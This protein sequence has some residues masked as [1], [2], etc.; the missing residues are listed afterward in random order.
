MKYTILGAGIAGIGAG[1]RLGSEAII[2]EA[3][4]RY[5]G[6]LDN[7]VV[8]G[9]RFDQAIHLSFA[10][11]KIVRDVFDKTKYITHKPN[12][13][14]YV[15]G[16]WAKH[17][18]QN[19][20]FNLP[21]DK[22]ILAVESLL[23][24]KKDE[25]NNYEDWLNSQFGE[26]FTQNYPAR[27]TRKY[28][29]C[30]PS[31]LSINWVANR[32]YRPSVKEIIEGALIDTKHSTYY[33]KELRY[34]KTGGYRNFFEHIAENLNIKLNHKVTSI[35]L[36]EKAIEFNSRKKI[37]YKNLISSLPLPE[38][39]N[40]IQEVPD[41]VKEAA[42]KLEATSIILGSVGFNKKI[43]VPGLWFYIY[44]EDIPFARV[45]APCIK[46]EAN[47]PPNKFS[48]QF[49]M[50]TSKKNP[51]KLSENSLK[52]KIL[53]ALE[54][55]NL[56]TEKDVIFIDIRKIKYGNVIFY[57]GMENNRKIVKDY[58]S[59]NEIISIGRFGEWDYLWSNQSFLSGYNSV[60]Q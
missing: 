7:F 31:E 41:A 56:A 47:C 33:A 35:N 6:L 46:S 39:I 53:K 44:D 3:K 25:I 37:S 42:D 20:L 40:L 19:N 60:N 48:L 54:I 12:P 49:E 24:P 10:N 52:E 43:N 51:N 28:W 18:L 34:P 8:E 15:D 38:I 5:G 26:Y 32:V 17:P 50:Y 11:E 29:G 9:F 23:G 4:S 27:Y 13:Y 55:M 16:V 57:T 1:Y 36:K 59:D 45:H 14:N 2:Y 21:T 30:E 58:L 22:K